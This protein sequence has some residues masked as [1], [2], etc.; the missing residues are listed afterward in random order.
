MV[1]WRF[2]Y[3]FGILVALLS[4]ALAA[5]ACTTDYKTYRFLHETKPVPGYQVGYRTHFS[6]EYP[7]GYRLVHKYARSAPQAPIS[8]RFSRGTITLG[9]EVSPPTHDT[10]NAERSV[11]RLISALGD[12]NPVH[13]RSSANIS[14]IAA[15]M[16]AF[17]DRRGPTPLEVREIIFDHDDRI[18][19]L[20]IFYPG[21][22]DADQAKQHLEH[23]I[24]TFKILP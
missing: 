2:F 9:V 19:R 24:E 10:P 7:A 20:F 15:E 4:V 14:G 5:G 22:R 8:V 12:A 23:I 17:A 21:N 13:E 11:Y 18:W 16:I 6:F 3:I 1:L